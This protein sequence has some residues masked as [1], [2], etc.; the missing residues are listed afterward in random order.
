MLYPVTDR[1]ALILAEFREG[2]VSVPGTPSGSRPDG[3]SRPWRMPVPMVRLHRQPTCLPLPSR[4]FARRPWRRR[5]RFSSVALQRFIRGTAMT[6]AGVLQGRRCRTYAAAR[7]QH[8]SAA[9][10]SCG[11]RAFPQAL[12]RHAHDMQIPIP[13]YCCTG[14]MACCELKFA[15]YK[16]GLGLTR[17]VSF[18]GFF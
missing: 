1:V 15:I 12:R 5:V 17:G 11:V 6:Y 7:G 16:G 8:T 3:D 13:G 18:W 10:F 9:S 14:V 2:R 4:T